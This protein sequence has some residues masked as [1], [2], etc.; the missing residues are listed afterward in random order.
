MGVSIREKTVG[1]MFSAE[2]AHG[3]VVPR[4]QREYA[5]GRAEISALLTD[6]WESFHASP[7]G[8]YYLGTLVVKRLKSDERAGVWEVIDGQQRLTT[9][10]LLRPFLRFECADSPLLFATRRITNVFLDDYCHGGEVEKYFGGRAGNAVPNSFNA[11]IEL[12]RSFKPALKDGNEHRLSIDTGLLDETREDVIFREFICRQVVLFEVVMPDETDEMDY[13]EVMNNRGEQLEFHEILKAQL[14]TKLHAVCAGKDAPEALSGKYDVLSRR[15]NLLWTACSKM[16]GHVVDHLHLTYAFREDPKL[17][18]TDLP[19]VSRWDDMDESGVPHERQSVI[20]DFSNFLMHVLRLYVAQHEELYGPGIVVPLDE[21][22]IKKVFDDVDKKCPVDPVQF[23]Q[24]LVRTRLNYDKYV[25]KAKIE[26][27]IV[28]EWRL[29]EIVKRSGGKYDAKCTFGKGADA[30]D[31]ERVQKRLVCLQSALQVSNAVQRYK[32]WVY[33]ILSASESVRSDGSKLLRLLEKFVAM[34]IA[35]VQAEWR[36]RGKNDLGRL[37]LQTPRLLFNVIDYLM[38]D[39]S[40]NRRAKGV[41]F[42]FTVPRDFVFGYQNS[43]EHHHAQCDDTGDEVWEEHDKN[44]IGNLYLTSTSENSSMGKHRTKE[45]VSIY[46]HAH[47]GENPL[48]P[49]RNWMYVHTDETWPLTSMNTLAAYVMSLVERLLKRFPELN[50]D[51]G[52]D[53]S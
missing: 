10:T 5:W 43:I 15:F 8:K 47:A 19:A 29:K 28:V 17:C 46:Q 13:F 20:R 2:Y 40:E 26:N 9:L 3:Y 53:D 21:R 7:H 34:R 45:K 6:L 30:T 4:Y 16:D 31:D 36:D 11:A 48:N 18:W 51:S 37:G 23:L 12:I 44:C 24:M 32:E 50:N 1:E 35:A 27:D 22:S 25:V 39:E 33:E 49:K 52:A 41:P 14:L 42:E 38:W